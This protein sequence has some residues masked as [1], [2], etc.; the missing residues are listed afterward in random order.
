M[1]MKLTIVTIPAINNTIPAGLKILFF[2]SR[3][4]ITNP[5]NQSI[6]EM[7]A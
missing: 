7:I 6:E 2:D 5:D 1:D 4:I 3:Y